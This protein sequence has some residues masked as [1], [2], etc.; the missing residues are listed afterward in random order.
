MTTNSILIAL[1]A[2]TAVAATL[3]GV[4]PMP[5]PAQPPPPE[6]KARLLRFF[7][8]KE[9]QAK[10]LTA[11]EGKELA[12]EVWKFFAAGK[13]GDWQ[14]VADLYS[15]MAKGAYQFQNETYDKRLETMAWQPVNESFRAYQQC[16]RGDS[17]YVIQYAEEILKSMPA[18]SI[19]FG[20]TD[21]GR[22]LP[23]LFSKSHEKAEPCFV[24]TQNQLS[25]GLYLGYLRSMYGGR[26]QI[27][28]DDDAARA[29]NETMSDAVRRYHSHALLPGEIINPTNGGRYT[30]TGPVPVWSISGLVA[31]ITFDKNPGRDFFVEE[32]RP[33]DWMHP[34][35]VP[36][37]LIMKLELQPQRELSPEAVRRDH[38]FW[39]RHTG[40]FIGNWIT[41]DTS[42]EEVCDFAVKVYK[43]NDAEAV[44]RHGCDLRFIRNDNA[45]EM[46]AKLRDS[47]GSSIYAWR[48]TN[49]TPTGATRA[50]M[51]KESAYA[52]KQA[53]AMC[54]YSGEIAFHLIALL[55]GDGRYD[56]ALVV[57]KTCWEFDRENTGLKDLVRQLEQIKE[58][59]APKRP[60]N[61]Q[62]F[63]KGSSEP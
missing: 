22:W 28:S 27:P 61:P 7:S 14:G 21:A 11:Q 46:F 37:G 53:F 10:K 6:L 42:I 48:I 56:D 23:T 32:S 59:P 29:Y 17:R 39:G 40:R 43:N 13:T 8:D 51:A 26:I 24:L 5:E 38:E 41:Y 33:I 12:P 63:P 18:G 45:H 31:K 49:G 4:E 16:A 55:A 34:H 54:P 50:W 35:L 20:G 25:D 57:G 9:I 19:Y 1:C 36:F 3:A 58:S 2:V 52:L 30:L 60:A 47:I 44:R 15:V 62:G